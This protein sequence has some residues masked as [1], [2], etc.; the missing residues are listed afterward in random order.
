MRQLSMASVFFSSFKRDAGGNAAVEFGFIAPLLLLML[1]GTVE[2]GRAINM[3]RHFVAAVATTGDLVA[4]EQ[5]LGT[6]ESAAKANLAGMMASIG[7]MMKP[8]DA[9][10]LKLS[11]FSVAVSANDASKAKV[12]WGYNYG[13]SPPANCADY[14]LPPEIAA[15]GGSVIVVDATYGF[16]ALFGSF[17][18]G[19]NPQMNWTEK[20]Y[21]SPR[22]ACVDYVQGNNCVNRC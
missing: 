14:T 18:P 16:T 11:V 19:I 15:K 10:K 3:D 9:S 7:H 20:S 8:Y 2:L 21:N 6:S 17:V 22:N 5:Y 1:L 13:K 12:Q 4:R